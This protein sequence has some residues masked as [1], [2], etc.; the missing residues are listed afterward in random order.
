MV[1]PNINIDMK[2]KI[3]TFPAGMY[4]TIM[5]IY[6]DIDNNIL[7]LQLDGEVIS[8]DRKEF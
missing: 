5:R 7:T 6:D 3:A 2:M 4:H 1:I 8:K